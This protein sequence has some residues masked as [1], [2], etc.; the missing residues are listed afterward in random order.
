MH[1]IWCWHCLVRAVSF[2]QLLDMIALLA[3]KAALQKSQELDSLRI[4]QATSVAKCALTATNC[5]V[6]LAIHADCR[7]SNQDACRSYLHDAGK[8]PGGVIFLQNWL[9]SQIAYMHSLQWLEYTLG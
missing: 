7:L 9:R 2:N 5:A 6:I 4:G 1:R 8:V 3:A